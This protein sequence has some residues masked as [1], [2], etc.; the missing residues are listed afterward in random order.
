MSYKDAYHLKVKADL[1]KLDKPVV[2]EIYSAH[3]DTILVKPYSERVYTAILKECLAIIFGKT[4]LITELP[5]LLMRR[6]RLFS[7]S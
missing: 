6:K 3:L 4:R 7:L 1:K 5:I 2:K